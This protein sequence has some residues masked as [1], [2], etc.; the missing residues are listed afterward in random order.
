MEISAAALSRRSAWPNVEISRTTVILKGC[1][2]GEDNFD[3]MVR[4]TVTY[5]K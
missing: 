5:L 4:V 1:L 2:E 3:K